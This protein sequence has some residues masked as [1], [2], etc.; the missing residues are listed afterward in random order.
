MTVKSVTGA[1]L[2]SCSALG[3]AGCGVTYISPTVSE[4]A[5]GLDVRV[6][7]ITAENVL[8]ANR[9]PYT[10]RSLPP[11][12]SQVAGVGSP[13]GAGAFPEMPVIP[14]EVP[15]PLELRV[16]GPVTIPPYQIG[17]GD[18]LRLATRPGQTGVID[19]LQAAVAGQSLRS[20]YLVR[21][22]GAIAIPEVGPVQVAGLTLEEAEGA[23]F[24]RLIEAGIDPAFSLEI[25]GFNARRATV[26]GNVGNPTLVPITLNTLNLG[27]ALTAAGGI[28]VQDPQFASIRIFRDGT[29]YQI[30]IEDF[31]RDSA[32]RRIPVIEGDAIFVDTSYDLDRALSYFQSQIN[33]IALRRQDRT[34]ALSELQTEVGLRR[35][36]LEE[37]RSVFQARTNLGAEAR[38]YVYLTGEFRSNSRWALPYEQQANLADAIYANGGFVTTTGNPAQI[39]VLRASTNPAEFGAVTAWHLDARNP[40]TITLATRFLLRPDDVIFIEEQP[41]TRWNRALQQFFPILISTAASALE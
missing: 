26:G 29:L 18:Q 19:P 2:L 3:L 20:E 16:P 33:V 39:Y 30:P 12:F 24:Q 41:I 40:A 36:N 8:F 31:D 14:T 38:D 6:L 1:I 4:Q 5:Q 34:A 22:D 32:L 21:D 9:A 15:R 35:G 28:R 11:A 17:V 10:P 7:P 37:Q 13:R 27:E 25:S 23:I